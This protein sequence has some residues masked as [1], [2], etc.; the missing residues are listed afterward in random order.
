MMRKLIPT[1]WL[2]TVALAHCAPVQAKG[3]GDEVDFQTQIRPIFEA[4]CIGCHGPEKQKHKLRLDRRS[5]VFRGDVE[6]PVI[7]PGKADQSELLRRISLPA[8]DEDR[9]PGR[10]EKLTAEQVALIK[11]WIDQGARWPEEKPAATPDAPKGVDFEKQIWPIL[12]ANCVRCHGPEKQKGELRF[13]QRASVFNREQAD[14]I[15]QP[16]SAEKSKLY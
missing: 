10:G 8:D 14:R 7:Q 4:R 11:A 12:E 13:D 1:L 2:A 16:G 9:M 5:G 15:I 6:H 3:D